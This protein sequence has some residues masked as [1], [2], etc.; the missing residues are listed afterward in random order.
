[1]AHTQDIWNTRTDRLCHLEPLQQLQEEIG[2][3]ESS[4]GLKTCVRQGRFMYIGI[5]LEPD[6][7]M[8]DAADNI[9]CTMLQMDYLLNP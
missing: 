3:S 1:M 7:Q 9:A 5:S 4:F 6:D 2:N 8:G